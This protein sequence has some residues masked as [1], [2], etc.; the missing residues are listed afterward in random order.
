MIGVNNL[1]TISIDENFVKGVAKKILVGE[2]KRGK[3][4]SIA[5]VGSDRI[6]EINK[7]YRKKNQTTDVLSFSELEIPMEKFKVF[8]V[9]EK[10]NLGEII[11]CLKR[12]KRNAK[13]DGSDFKT[14]FVRV[15]IHGVLHLLGYDHKKPKQREEMKNKQD[16]YLSKILTK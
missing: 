10:E 7:K 9:Q 6:K 13:K 1:T 16:F 15:L 3:G 14:E 5:F 11:I 2:G 8:P 12:V 4:L